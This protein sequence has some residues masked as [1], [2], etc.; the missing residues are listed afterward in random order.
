MC[1]GPG[2]GGSRTRKGKRPGCLESQSDR[3]REIRLQK[4]I[5]ATPQGL[6]GHGEVLVLVPVATGSRRKVLSR[7]MT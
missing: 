4:S 7:V 6:G 5:E 3:E 2:A 1:K